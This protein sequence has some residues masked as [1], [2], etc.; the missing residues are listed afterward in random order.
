ME[1][2]QTVIII[3]E[4]MLE[5]LVSDLGTVAVFGGLIGVGWFLDSTAMQWGGFVIGCV[6]LLGR[7]S[8]MVQKNRMTIAQARKKLDELE[9]GD[10][11]P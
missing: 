8:G 6:Y 5:G 4:T 1:D 11:H 2:K 3:R 10:T 7:A 9:R